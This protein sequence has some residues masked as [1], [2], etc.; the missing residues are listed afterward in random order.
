MRRRDFIRACGPGA[1]ISLGG[2]LSGDSSGSYDEA[3]DD[4][5]ARW[6][7]PGDVYFPGHRVGMK[8]V[9][10]KQQ[11]DRTVALSYKYPARFWTVTGRQTQR[12]GV[13][14]SYSSI[15]LMVSVW[16][17]ETGTVLPVDA[18]L[19]VRILRDGELVTE[20]AL[21][22]M[23]SQRMGFHF[24]DNISFP[25][26]GEH[27]VVVDLNEV[28]IER[29]GSFAD[30]FEDPVSLDFTYEFR[31]STRNGIAKTKTYKRRGERDA[32]SPMEMGMLP[33]SVAP[34]AASLPGQVI[35][36]QT[37]GDAE[38]V[39]TSTDVT[40][41]TYVTISPRTPY[42]QFHLPQM[43]LS[44][45]VER[46]GETLFENPLTTAIGPERGY[47]HRALV[48]GLEPGD[49][50]TVSVDSPPQVARHAGYETA[51][52]QMSDITVTV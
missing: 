2:C 13:E 33:L 48:D 37:S 14:N 23:L 10:V 27:S 17:T 49:E 20:R 43:A 3:Y 47:H 38:F 34:T 18:G 5:T 41:K 24:G 40:D 30:R 12:V 16:D 22:P 28:Q 11:G 15:H 35:G 21:W 9:G 4:P 42:N 51:F 32:L 50:I 6:S 44:M 19:R 31:R 1:L 25:D 46:D 7:Q 26:H 52:L 39:V 36:E 8:M 29:E 45:R